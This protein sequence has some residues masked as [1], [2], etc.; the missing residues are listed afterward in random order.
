MYDDPATEV[1]AGIS[2]T[3]KPASSHAPDQ[4]EKMTSRR[5]GY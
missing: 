2:V 4:R 1:A 5:S 3:D